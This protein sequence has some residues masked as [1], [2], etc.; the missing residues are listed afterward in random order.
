V[1]APA[2]AAG[3]DPRLEK[4]MDLETRSFE[5]FMT[6]IVAGAV[7]NRAEELRLKVSLHSTKE[8]GYCT[9]FTITDSR[10]ESVVV[11]IHSAVVK[12]SA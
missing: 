8:G 6:G 9:S 11:S 2:V 12:P 5:L 10:G 3:I 4:P 1:P 7:M